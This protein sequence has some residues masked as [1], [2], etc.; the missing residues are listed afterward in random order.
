MKKSDYNLLKLQSILITCSIISPIVTSKLI[1]TNLKLFN[2]EV[3]FSASV[4]IYAVVFMLSNVITE[5][6]GKVYAVI[7][8]RVGIISQ[9]VASLLLFIVQLLPAQD[10]EIQD[11]YKL[12]LGSNFIF[13]TAGATAYFLSQSYNTFL[14]SQIRKRQ[15]VQPWTVNIVSTIVGQL[16]DTVVFLGLAFGLGLQY[17]FNT[18]QRNIL[19]VMMF[20]QY[21]LRVIIAFIEI[22][23]FNLLIKNSISSKNN[24]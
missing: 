7:T 4:F 14:Y 1:F 5:Q 12:I 15:K 21:I 10:A 18:E 3:T 6:Y 17:F 20:T 13:V 16:V 23:V 19:L 22:P 2:V 11:A 8:T 9:L 24:T